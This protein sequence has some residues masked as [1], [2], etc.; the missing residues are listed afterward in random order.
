MAVWLYLLTGLAIAI[1]CRKLR[2][3]NNA[4]RIGAATMPLL[5]S[6]SAL[7]QAERTPTPIWS[8]EGAPPKAYASR[9]VF[10]APDGHSVILILPRQNGAN[11]TRLTRVSLHNVIY[12]DLRVRIETVPGGFTYRYTLR[13]EKQSRD[14]VTVFSMAIYADP[15]VDLGAELWFPKS[16]LNR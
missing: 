8:G 12:P 16:Q 4:L 5:T 6:A 1:P 13:N 2:S 15:T 14:T 3:L 11:S 7:P 9:K 10:L